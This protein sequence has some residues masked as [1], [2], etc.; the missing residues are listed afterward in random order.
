[1]ECELEGTWRSPCE[2]AVLNAFTALLGF[3]LSEAIALRAA[4]KV[5][6]YHE[7][8]MPPHVASAI[9]DEWTRELAAR[10]RSSVTV[11]QD[12]PRGMP[13]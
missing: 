13:A 2:V 4:L 1:M 7:P 12:V 3:G 8:T 5:L 6:A 11:D 10:P 9:L